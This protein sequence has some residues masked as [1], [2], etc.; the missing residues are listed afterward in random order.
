MWVD[1]LV[2]IGVFTESATD[3]QFVESSKRGTGLGLGA[4]AGRLQGAHSGTN[5]NILL[6]NE[7]NHKRCDVSWVEAQAG[8]TFVANTCASSSLPRS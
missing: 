6:F 2:G 4:G 8:T 5:T 7:K 3:V 1:M